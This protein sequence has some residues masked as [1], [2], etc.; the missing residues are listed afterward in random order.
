MPAEKSVKK[1][2]LKYCNRVSII[3]HWG[4]AWFIADGRRSKEDED[5]E[6]R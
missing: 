1:T 4:E 2:I 3:V 6:E 5:N